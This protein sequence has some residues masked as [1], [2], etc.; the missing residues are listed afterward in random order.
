MSADEVNGRAF[1]APAPC[2]PAPSAIGAR[3][4]Q[5][6]AEARPRP[7]VG[8]GDHD[9]GIRQ[10]R[11]GR[12]FRGLQDR[13]RRHNH[14]VADAAQMREQLTHFGRRHGR[15][16]IARRPGQRQQQGIGPRVADQR[17]V[18]RQ[19]P[20][21]NLQKS[22][23]RTDAGGF[24][25]DGLGQM[26]VDQDG[27][28]DPAP[29]PRAPGRARPW[30]RQRAIRRSSRRRR[31]PSRDCDWA[32][33]GRGAPLSHARKAKPASRRC[34]PPHLRPRHPVC[35]QQRRTRGCCDRHGSRHRRRR[36]HRH[37]LRHRPDGDRLIAARTGEPHGKKRGETSE[38]QA[39]GYGGHHDQH[40][41]RRSRRRG[42]GRA[43]D[44]MR[45]GILQSFLIL[46]R[47]QPAQ[48]AS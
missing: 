47:G 30:C 19:G 23:L 48:D 37:R 15:L 26:S 35:R 12:R 38:Q 6:L 22:R 42:H 32:A 21:Q 41:L 46:D 44:H 14:D 31:G 13:R 11:E 7:L 36:A 43:A 28:Q 25:Q 1:S 17:P 8:M 40:A 2:R 39:G 5:R 27:A 33:R 29:P 20:A 18:E 34:D 16:G 45:V 4:R 9:D 10:P 24:R 3:R